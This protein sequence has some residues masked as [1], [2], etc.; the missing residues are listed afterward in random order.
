MN[1]S[2]P[3]P[4]AQDTD[5]HRVGSVTYETEKNLLQG[6]DRYNQD[7]ISQRKKR[8]KI[9]KGRGGVSRQQTLLEGL[10]AGR[11]SG[12]WEILHIKCF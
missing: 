4:T 10:L 5:T 8:V 9:K 3:E 11:A 1:S 12:P 2:S 7:Y 6:S